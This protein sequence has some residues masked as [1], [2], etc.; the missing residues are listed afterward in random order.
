LLCASDFIYVLT[1]TT[2]KS[3]SIFLGLVL[4]DA[5]L[6]EATSKENIYKT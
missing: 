4:Q 3:F 1:G 2:A 5:F 6:F